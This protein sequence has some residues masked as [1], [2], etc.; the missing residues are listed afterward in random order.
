ME[1]PF[2]G[3]EALAAGTVTRRGLASRFEPVY[4]D[5][6]LARDA[7]M[8][9]AKRAVAAW[10]W[11]G[12]KATLTGLSAS[13]VYGTRWIDPAAPAELYRRN[14]KP[15]TGILVH[16]DELDADETRLFTG[17]PV[18]T[19]ARTAFDLGRR[20]GRDEAVIQV[21]ALSQATRLCAADIAPLL[22]RHPGARGL[23]QLRKVL[24]LMDEGAESP[25][26]TRTRL[27]LI[28]AGLP[29]P[30]TQIVVRGNF[31]ARRSARI[32]MGYSQFKVGVEYEGVQHWTDP[33]VRA[34]DIDRYAELAAQGWIIIR[35]SADMLRHR[36]H[37]IVARTCEALRVRGAEWP[38]IARKSEDRVA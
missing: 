24:D 37:V 8:T 6:Y 29:K 3:T 26:E 7:E 15:A 38:V 13:A 4:R 11:S 36:P 30:Q 22:E 21:D 14:G 33:R 16:R 31:G 18:T 35:V 9:A 10:L 23:V 5:V 12:R 34:N 27:V 32:D 1:Q 17:L 2:L 19:P 28:D 20:P 25:Q